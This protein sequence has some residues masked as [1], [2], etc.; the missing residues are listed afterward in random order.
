MKGSARRS[1]PRCP[2]ERP[3]TSRLWSG[4]LFDPWPASPAGTSRWL[5][6]EQH[7]RA[8]ARQEPS[9]DP[10]RTIRRSESMNAANVFRPINVIALTATLLALL[11]LALLP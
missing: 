11:A 1:V 7:D 4:L 5:E 3:V 6:C 10:T 2:V 8:A 9:N